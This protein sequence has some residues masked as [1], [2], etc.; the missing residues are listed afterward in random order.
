MYVQSKQVC[1]EGDSPTRIKAR[2]LV[3]WIAEMRE[4]NSLKSID[5]VTLGVMSESP[6]RNGS[7]RIGG[8]ENLE[9]RKLSLQL[10][11][12]GSMGK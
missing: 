2:S 8:L 7:E 3:A 4:T 12:E 6:G 10:K 5:K 11:G 1:S 9:V